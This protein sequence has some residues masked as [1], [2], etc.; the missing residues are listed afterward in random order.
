VVNEH[1]DNGN[2]PWMIGLGEMVN[3]LADDADTMVQHQ[4]TVQPEQGQEMRN[5]TPWPQP[6]APAPQP[7][8]PEPRPL[9][10]SPETYIISGLE[11]FGL[12]T[13]QK[14][15]PAA[16]TLREAEPAGNITDVDVEQ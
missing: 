10:R 7:Q 8:I 9:P 13:P 14:P 15:H 4:P 11:F 1:E 6:P 5:H 3:T 16:A 2:E 12:V